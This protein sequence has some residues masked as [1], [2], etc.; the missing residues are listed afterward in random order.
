MNDLGG[1]PMMI[2]RNSSA[3][4][5][6]MEDRLQSVEGW[7]GGGEPSVACGMPTILSAVC[8]ARKSSAVKA[9][10]FRLDPA[11]TKKGVERVPQTLGFFGVGNDPIL[12]ICPFLKIHT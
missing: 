7:C 11:T 8:E 4:T 6:L 1:E 3:V 12:P 10:A 2:R 5:S 9:S